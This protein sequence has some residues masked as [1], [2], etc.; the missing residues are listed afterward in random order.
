MKYERHKDALYDGSRP[1]FPG[2]IK[3]LQD[4]KN[5]LFYLN[6]SEVTTI[7]QKAFG[8]KRVQEVTR[9]PI[10]TNDRHSWF[11]AVNILIRRSGYITVLFPWKGNPIASHPS[12]FRDDRSIALYGFGK[13]KASN[14]VAVVKK[15]TIAFTQQAK[16]QRK[17]LLR[18]GRS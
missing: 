13:V 11:V 4:A 7:A 18:Q 12:L 17:E 16:I 14:F 9:I 8:E 3:A 6:R 5:K 2:G 10:I 1:R 15:L